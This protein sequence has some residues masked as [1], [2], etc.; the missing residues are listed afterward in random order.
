MRVLQAQHI[1]VGVYDRIASEM[2]A[3]QKND[4]LVRYEGATSM[5]IEINTNYRLWQHSNHVEYCYQIFP[6][7]TIVF[8]S[9]KNE[10]TKL[11]DHKNKIKLGWILEDSVSG[12]HLHVKLNP[13]CR[14]VNINATLSTKQTEETLM[15]V[16]LDECLFIARSW[17]GRRLNA[18]CKRTYNVIL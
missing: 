3:A 18:P 13:K 5:K 2:W 17:S 6:Y 14:S 8:E 7:T 11:F 16:R 10:R 9:T 1:A 4:L 15:F 12:F